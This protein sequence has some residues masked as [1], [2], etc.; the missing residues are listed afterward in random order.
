MHLCFRSLLGSLL[1]MCG[2]GSALFLPGTSWTRWQL[3]EEPARVSGRLADGVTHPRRQALPAYELLLLAAGSHG[4]HPLSPALRRPL[5][6]R[7]VPEGCIA[8]SLG[9]RSV[10]SARPF[11]FISC[12]D[13]IPEL[14]E[15]QFPH[16]ESGLVMTCQGC[17]WEP[18][19]C[20]RHREVAGC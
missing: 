7:E 8:G 2:F 15:P 20:A 5:Y 3:S 18:A 6:W 12:T 14:P 17:Y 16:Q 19:A 10:E 13:K 9:T 11:A 4:P 1:C